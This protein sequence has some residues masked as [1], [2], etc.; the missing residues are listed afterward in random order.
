VAECFGLSPVEA[1]ASR[2]QYYIFGILVQQM[3]FPKP[4]KPIPLTS[5][6]KQLASPIC[7]YSATE[8]VVARGAA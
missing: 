1:H 8:E 3:T 7:I 2:E 6:Q 5:L 4:F